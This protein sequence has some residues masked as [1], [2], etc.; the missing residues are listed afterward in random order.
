MRH[1]NRI[2]LS[3]LRAIEAAG[4]AGTLARAAEELGVTSGALSQRISKAE[5]LLGRKLFLRTPAG[6]VP[7][8]LCA[9]VLPRLTRAMLELDA[10]VEDIDATRPCSLVVSVAPIFASR[11]LI[12]RIRRFNELWPGI[13][14][15]IEPGVPLVDLDT[16]D[17]DVGIRVG[18]APGKGVEAVKLL[19]QRIF[20]VCT[21]ELAGT[22]RTEEDL[23]ELPVIREN[24]ELYG[25]E[26]WLA[27]LGRRPTDLPGGPT[28]RDA[29]LC[30]DAAMTG[31]GLFM[32]WE[33]L[34]CDA[35]ERG[36]LAAPFA[37]RESTGAAYWFVT[38]S[39]ARRNPSVMR[40]R[41]WL[42]QEMA[43]S[44]VNWRRDATN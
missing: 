12:W 20:P 29:S 28:Y 10:I 32:A 35:L 7:T 3:G 39:K 4:R 17:V 14:V 2:P 1:L 27:P 5:A 43:C 25:W 31:Q 30:L 33:T 21:P 8:E 9:N 36:R 22:I 24:E 34:A 13:S 26:E 16:S 6:L 44:V 11:W 15:R 38:G 42:Q 18:R 41:Q 19:D 37:R 40:F 23:F